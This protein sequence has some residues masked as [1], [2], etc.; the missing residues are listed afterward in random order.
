M[1]VEAKLSLPLLQASKSVAKLLLGRCAFLVVLFS[2][3]IGG[4]AGKARAAGDAQSLYILRQLAKDGVTCPKY[5]DAVT[6]LIKGAVSEY[7]NSP[8]GKQNPDGQ[9]EII[10]DIIAEAVKIRPPCACDIVK[11]GIQVLTPANGSPDPKLVASMVAEVVQ[12]IQATNPDLLETIVVCATEADP[13]AG[14]L[15]L[16]AVAGI[17][18]TAKANSLN[19]NLPT[20][21][22]T[23]TPTP[24]PKAPTPPPQVTPVVPI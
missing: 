2:L 9:Y 22:A 18:G 17:L 13:D 16:N 8:K 14:K 12:Y 5:V 4:M 23:P 1:K 3:L 15:I 20:G 19:M 24:T 10:N 21:F 7:L 6:T 11:A